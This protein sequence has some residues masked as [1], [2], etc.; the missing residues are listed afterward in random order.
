MRRA[1]R[2]LGAAVLLGGPAALAFF[3][4]G[5]FDEP[6]L[7]AAIAAW[8]LVVLAAFTCERPLPRRP[9]G[10]MALAGLALLCG[11]TALSFAWSPLDERTLDDLQRLLLFL[12]YTVAAVAFLRPAPARRAVEPALLLGIVVVVGYA[13]SERLLPG[14][15]ELDRNRGAAGRLEQPLTYWNAMGALAAL[16]VVLAARLAGDGTRSPTLRAAAAA[17][18]PLVALGV[19][20]SFSRGAIAAAA[21]GLLALVLLA[22]EGRAQLRAVLA[23][24]GAGVV[25]AVAAEAIAPTVTS[26]GPGVEGESGRGAAMLAVLAVLGGAA[27]L[28]GARETATGAGAARS[29]R[30]AGAGR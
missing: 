5:Y 19:Y 12:G 11:W 1:L 16:G 21:V 23:V 3:S 20:V 17:V 29:R 24:A 27:A 4:G 28:A 15:V 25:A 7:I 6:R 10:L 22:P 13:L 30:C 8:A 26:L 2:A 14:L 18:S 9:E